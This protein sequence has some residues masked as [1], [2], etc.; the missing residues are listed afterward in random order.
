MLLLLAAIS[1]FIAFSCQK[2]AQ[3][4]I[5]TA[6]AEFKDIKVQG[7]NGLVGLRLNK[8]SF[9][10]IIK[11]D[12]NPTNEAINQEMLN[13]VNVLKDFVNNKELTKF[14]VASAKKSQSGAVSVKAIMEKF[15]EVAAKLQQSKSS[16]QLVETVFEHEGYTYEIGISIPNVEQADDDLLPVLGVGLDLYDDV[17]NN[18]PDLVFAYYTYDSGSQHQVNVGENEAFQVFNPVC[19]AV[20]LLIESQ[21]QVQLKGNTGNGQGE[22]QLRAQER[23][24][25]QSYLLRDRFDRSAHTEFHMAAAKPNTNSYD[26]RLIES[27]HGSQ[28]GSQRS[29]NLTL[30]NALIDDLIFNTYE[31]DWYAS[32]KGLGQ[33]NNSGTE[34]Q[35]RRSYANEWYTFEPSKVRISTGS[36]IWIRRDLLFSNGTQGFTFDA[37]KGSMTLGF[38]R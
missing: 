19:V 26:D 2:E 22:V 6:Y 23:T 4:S 15:P 32:R 25:I 1:T 36:S 28:V 5:S 24:F 21:I 11:D 38:T 17:E 13:V 34:M 8:T 9:E 27:M 30:R 7:K 10:D 18:N 12:A 37:Q 29:P 33:I 3:P 16:N 14:M 31:R 35:V 20:P